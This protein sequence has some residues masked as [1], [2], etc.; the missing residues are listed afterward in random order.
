MME[1]DVRNI[2]I[3]S[4]GKLTDAR[5]RPGL[6][7]LCDDPNANVPLTQLGL[8]SLDA[9]EWCMEIESRC[10]VELDPAELASL[11]SVDDLIKLLTT[12]LHQAHR[13]S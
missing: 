11:V 13:G 4:L 1:E 12:R 10:S 2:V 5:K 8:D 9:M 6:R 3:Q 7:E